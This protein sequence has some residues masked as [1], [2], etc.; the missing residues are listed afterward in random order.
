MIK[1]AKDLPKELLDI[2]R[3]IDF[4]RIPKVEHKQKIEQIRQLAIKHNI[5]QRQERA[6]PVEMDLPGCPQELATMISGLDFSKFNTFTRKIAMGF[7][8]AYMMKNGFFKY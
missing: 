4:S 1:I 3:R 7:I 8:E 6:I 5:P 2:A